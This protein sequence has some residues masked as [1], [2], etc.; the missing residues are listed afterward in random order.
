MRRKARVSRREDFYIASEAM[1]KLGLARTVFYQKVNAGQIP[2]VTLPGSKQSLYPKRDIDTLALA[3]DWVFKSP[4]RII[5]SSSSPG[6]QLEELEIGVLCFG[7]EYITPL[8]ERIAFQQASGFT[9]WNLKVNGRVA[10]YGSTFRFPSDFLDDI[11]TGQQI[12]RA[13]TVKEVLKFSRTEPFDIYIDVLASDPRLPAHLRKRY[14]GL[15]VAY[16]ANKILDLLANGYKIR[17][18]YTVTATPEGDKMVKK[19]GFQLM[20]GK[21]Q[22]KGR[23]AYQ[24]NLDKKGLENMAELQLVL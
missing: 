11:L 4:E 2:K 17:T 10:V 6:D 9:F 20:E 15:F 12:E 22:K 8:P 16:F 19:L 24:Y 1:K 14:S 7:S 3:I 18:L 21:S 13:I 5:F 23:I